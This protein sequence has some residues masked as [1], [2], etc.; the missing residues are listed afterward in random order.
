MKEPQ[1]KV[2]KISKSGILRIKIS[3]LSYFRLY[4]NVDEELIADIMY[5]HQ[6]KARSFFI[7]KDYE[8]SILS[9]FTNYLQKNNLTDK[10]I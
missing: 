8:D 10:I 5:Y 7:N 3:E 1:F 2:F 9:W 4:R 6:D